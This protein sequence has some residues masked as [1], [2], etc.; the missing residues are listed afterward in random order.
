MYQTFWHPLYHGQRLAYCSRDYTMCGQEI[1][2]KY[3]QMLGYDKASEQQI[4]SNI[5]LTQYLAT[6]TICKDWRCNGFTFISCSTRLVSKNSAAYLY[7]SKEFTSPRYNGYRVDYCYEKG[8]SCGTR[9]ALSFCKRIG[10][11]YVKSFLK[12][13]QIGMTQTI[14]SHE[15]CVGTACNSFRSIVCYR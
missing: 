7:R 5:G 13:H 4:A 2:Q 1:A 11:L 15:L 6:N 3:C 10:Y 12:E 8:R 9:A 14:G